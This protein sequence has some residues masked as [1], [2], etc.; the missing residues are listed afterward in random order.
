MRRGKGSRGRSE[1][2]QGKAQWGLAVS[3]HGPQKC[4]APVGVTIAGYRKR[5]ALQRDP[6]WRLSWERMDAKQTRGVETTEG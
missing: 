2:T 1:R 6:L 3:L 4:L 5:G